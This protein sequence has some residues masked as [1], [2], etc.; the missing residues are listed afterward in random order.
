M[1]AYPERT[2][3]EWLAVDRDGR[4]GVFT[5]AGSGPIPTVYLDSEGILEQVWDAVR[6][7][8]EVCDHDLLVALPRPD[9]FISFARR[10]FF[11]YDW[12]DV[13]GAGRHLGRRYELQARPLAPVTVDSVR[14]PSPLGEVLTHVRSAALDFR[15]VTVDVTAAFGCASE[16]RRTPS[17]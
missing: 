17:R 4:V 1:I 15:D 6:G 13:Q 14:W 3:V 2:D 7:L 9:D 11:S 8:P 5:T 12:A 16:P 10:G